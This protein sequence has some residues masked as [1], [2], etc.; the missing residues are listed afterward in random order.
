MIQ[1]LTDEE[2][3]RAETIAQLEGLAA[4]HSRRLHILDQQA[5]RYAVAVPAN[6]AL[7]QDETRRQLESVQGQLRRCARLSTTGTRRMSA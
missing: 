7:E 3:E 5:A 1:T 2:I 6:I 4:I